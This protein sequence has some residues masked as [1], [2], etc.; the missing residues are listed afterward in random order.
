MIVQIII[1]YFICAIGSFFEKGEV[2]KTNVVYYLI[3][4]L[5]IL[6]T[7]FR[8]GES[9]TDYS[10]YEI[11]YDSDSN[12]IEP[13]FIFIR[14]I[15]KQFLGNYITILFFIYAVVAILL[16]FIAI[17]QLS[18]FIYISL[19]IFIGDLF[20]QQD[21]TQI[22][23]AV[24]TSLLLFCIK[25]LYERN[26]LQF[27]LYTIIATL[28]HVS[29]IMVLFLWFLN[30]KTINVWRYII[31]I[32]IGYVMAILKIDILGFLDYV[33][34]E[35]VQKKFSMYRTAQE[36]GNYEANI[37]SVLHLTKLCIYLFLL[38]NVNI[39]LEK[40]KY[41][42]ILLKIMCISLCGLIFFSQNMAAG[43][44]V[45]E[46]FGIVNIILFPLLIYLIKPV[47]LTKIILITIFFCVLCMR[48]FYTNLIIH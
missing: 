11:L 2:S 25:P 12:F 31:I 21:F 34:I 5:L 4:F 48:I 14:Y 6:F 9:V 36:F 37:F 47:F 19:I 1:L 26:F 40:N 32:I 28:F 3:C 39:L 20:L 8:D 15:V 27:I 33:P 13:T 17:R 29:S 22:R 18:P 46:L 42:I 16:K 24:A 41:S 43:I 7:A 23:A 35:Y 38:H 44:R 45:T 10:A 30:P